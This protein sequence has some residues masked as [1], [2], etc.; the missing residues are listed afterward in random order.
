[1]TVPIATTSAPAIPLSTA[2]NIAKRAAP[3]IIISSI[4]GGEWSGNSTIAC[5]D[6]GEIEDTGRGLSSNNEIFAAP[7]A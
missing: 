7:T 4:W 5:A 6:Q 1:M 3:A 2:Y